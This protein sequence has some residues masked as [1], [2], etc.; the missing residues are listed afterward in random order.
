MDPTVRPLG[1]SVRPTSTNTTCQVPHQRQV[2]SALR[3]LRGKNR[4]QETEIR[5]KAQLVQGSWEAE[6]RLGGGAAGNKKA[7]VVGRA[8]PGWCSG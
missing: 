7:L 8:L 2:P 6:G 4:L 3:E 5:F 1:R